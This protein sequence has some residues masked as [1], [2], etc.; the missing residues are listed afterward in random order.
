MFSFS[1]N[2]IIEQKLK[3]IAPINTSNG[4]F[5]SKDLS[6]IIGIN[7][8]AP[9]GGKYIFN[10]SSAKNKI[11]QARAVQIKSGNPKISFNNSLKMQPVK[12]AK[13]IRPTM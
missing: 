12:E 11:V 2:S 10:L 13:V 6:I 5:K 4:N 8:I 1:L 3:I 9:A 7:K